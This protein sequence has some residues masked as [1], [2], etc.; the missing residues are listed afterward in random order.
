MRFERAMRSIRKGEW[1][2][3]PTWTRGAMIALV[4]GRLTWHDG[5][6]VGE[7]GLLTFDVISA[8]DW[9][10]VRGGPSTSWWRRFQASQAAR[11]TEARPRG[12]NR[13]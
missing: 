1:V 6:P 10:V 4:K 5:T 2:R 8:G 11:A 12:G 13:Q 3:R 9:Q 7:F